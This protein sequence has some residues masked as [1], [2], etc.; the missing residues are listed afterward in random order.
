MEV[1]GLAFAVV[2]GKYVC[3]TGTGVCRLKTPSYD[4]HLPLC[5]NERS[6]QLSVGFIEVISNIEKKSLAAEDRRPGF[7]I[8]KLTC[9]TS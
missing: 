8:F 2:L 3:F 6:D 1:L 5:G 4:Q 7:L 9:K